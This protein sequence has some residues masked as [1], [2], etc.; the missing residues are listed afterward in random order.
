MTTKDIGA[1]GENAAVKTLKKSRY[2]ILARNIHISHNE[3]DIVALHK[4]SG[5]IVFVEVKTR[6]VNSDLY[7]PFGTPSDAV[8]KQKQMRT[9][10][11]ARGYLNANPRLNKYQPRFDVIEVY[12]EKENK[13]I[14]NTNHFENA[15]GL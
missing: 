15:F 11:A 3:L 12:L 7:S 2:K 6:S 9:I 13:K 1:I 10:Q 8:T 14:I 5:M 4:K